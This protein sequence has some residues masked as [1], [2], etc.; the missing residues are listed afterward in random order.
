MPSSA[1]LIARWQA[2]FESP[3]NERGDAGRFQPLEAK[4]TAG[5]QAAATR[6][7][8]SVVFVR[9]RRDPEEGDPGR[10][11]RGGQELFRVGHR[12]GPDRR[13]IRLKALDH[14]PRKLTAPA[15]T[16]DARLLLGLCGCY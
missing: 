7:R 4:P 5:Y 8:S 14:R 12:E 16:E 1:R 13:S 10:C 15:H 6:L 3:K 9:R 11:A 2:P